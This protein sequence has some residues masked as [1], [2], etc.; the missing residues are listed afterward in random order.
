MEAQ[1]LA[2]NTAT[3]LGG[4]MSDINTIVEA[5]LRNLGIREISEARWDD[6]LEAVNQLQYSWSDSLHHAPIIE[7]FTLVAGTASYTIGTGGVFDTSRPIKIMS[8]YIRDSSGNDHE[9]DLMPVDEYNRIYDKD[10]SGRPGRLYYHPSNTLGI[11]YFDKAPSEAETLYLTT[12]K[13]PTAYTLTSETFSMPVEYE[14]AFIFNLSIL[15]APQYNITPSAEVVN[16]ANLLLEQISARNFN[17]IPMA[18]FDS[19]IL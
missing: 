17:P 4:K 10:A 3:H 19:A 18:Q 2:E 16:M 13:P 7:N 1:W 14:L 9:V 11:I 8:A 15:L 12:I 6:A 5:S